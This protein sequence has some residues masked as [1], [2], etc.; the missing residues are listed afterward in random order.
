MTAFAKV[1]QVSIHQ[2]HPFSIDTFWAGIS[3]VL[4][5]KALY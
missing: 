1:N 5:F 2:S 4:S 3:G